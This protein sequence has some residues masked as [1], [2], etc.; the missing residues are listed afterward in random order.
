MLKNNTRNFYALPRGCKKGLE[1]Q[2]DMAAVCAGI[3]TQ[4]AKAG[5]SRSRRSQSEV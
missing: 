4:S 5:P 2:L 3:F 1:F